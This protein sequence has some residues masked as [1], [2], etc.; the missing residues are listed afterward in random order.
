MGLQEYLNDLLNNQLKEI[1]YRFRERVVA[2]IRD[3]MCSLLAG[4]EDEAFRTTILFVTEEEALF[5]NR[6]R[7]MR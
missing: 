5:S 1:K 7:Q 3:R 6:M 2:D 4:W